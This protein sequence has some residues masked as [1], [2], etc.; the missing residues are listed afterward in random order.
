[1]WD[2][3]CGPLRVEDPH[4]GKRTIMMRAALILG[5]L[6]ILVAMEWAAPP[7][8]K[9]ASTEPPLPQLAAD[10][11]DAGN[12]LTKADRLEIP[13][14]LVDAPAQPVSLIEP[15]RLAGSPA[16]MAEGV[17]KTVDPH[18]HDTGI[19]KTAVVLP[20]PRPKIRDSGNAATPD[21]SQAAT[22]S[23]SWEPKACRTNAIRDLLRTLNLVDRC[24]T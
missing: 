7:R 5:G 10:I 2:R 9:T 24:Q 23:K 1:M 15:A 17:A 12:T 14:A 19:G 6:G 4:S 20:K 16:I 22:E 18:R 11:G 8:T 13:H 3:C 21:R